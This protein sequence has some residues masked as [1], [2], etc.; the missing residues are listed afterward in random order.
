MKLTKYI[1]EAVDRGIQIA[2]DDFEDIEPNS[3]ISNND[4]I[5][6]ED[7]IKQKIELSKIV[8]DLDLPSGTLWCKYNLG[9]NPDQLSKP[10]DWYGNYYAW[11]ELNGIKDEYTGKTYKYAK[12]SDYYN[13]YD[14]IKYTYQDNLTQ[15]LPEDDAAYQNMYLYN[16][17]F[18]MPTKADF[19]ELRTGTN[20]EWVENFNNSGVNGYK[21]TNKSDSSK[22]IFL[23]A[24][25]YYNGSYLNLYGVGV[26]G[27]YWSSS[28]VT[29]NPICAWDLYFN[30]DE[31]YMD[32]S[33]R[34]CGFS[35][36][37]VINL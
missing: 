26:E 28:L 5:D 3:S 23:P 17:K 34:Y 12:P 2:L 29:D 32:R 11:G 33:H 9:V 1:L 14:M 21:F 37:P 24:A 25:G 15:L 6:A 30:S 27:N 31:V 20:N 18:K 10:E 35:V 22:Y 13:T 19:E 16:F 36:R 4:V 7:I 8:V